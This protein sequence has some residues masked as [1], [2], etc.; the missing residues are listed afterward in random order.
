MESNMLDIKQLS[1]FLNVSISLIRKLIRGNE[2]PYI[3]IGTKLLFQKN[4]INKW[5]L[6]QSGN[7]YQERKKE[8]NGK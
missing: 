8:Y 5:L 7:D 3:K 6:N 4:E 2:I 1:K